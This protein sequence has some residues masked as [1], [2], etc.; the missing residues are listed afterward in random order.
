MRVLTN[1]A[2][3]LSAGMLKRLVVN[4]PAAQDIQDAAVL[5]ITIL[6]AA[7]QP[8]DW[9]CGD[10]HLLLIDLPQHTVRPSC[11]AQPRAIAER[12]V[13]FHGTLDALKFHQA[14]CL[15]PN[16]NPIPSCS[17]LHVIL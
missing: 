10:I 6:P 13:N 8:Q 11:C 12:P 5:L 16:R 17:S 3:W 1:A 9:A 14:L 15:G 4:D 2:A 7:R